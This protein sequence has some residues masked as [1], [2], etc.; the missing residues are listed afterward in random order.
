[1]TKQ[2][3]AA[4]ARANYHRNKQPWIDAARRKNYGEGAPEHFKKQKAKQKNRCAICKTDMAQPCIDHDHKT[5][6]LRELLCQGCNIK[7]GVVESPLFKRV[8][9]YITKHQ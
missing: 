2:E 8:L 3:R 6:K 7:V 4:Y 9:K 5:G 1:M